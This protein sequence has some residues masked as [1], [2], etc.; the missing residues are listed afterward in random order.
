MSTNDPLV[1]RTL[2]RYLERYGRQPA[3]AGPYRD[4][5]SF[6][7]GDPRY[8]ACPRCRTLLRVDEQCD[9]CGIL[10]Q[11]LDAAGGAAAEDPF[12]GFTLSPRAA[13]IEAGVELTS[14]I[15]RRVC[16]GFA[17]AL[18]RC[19]HP[20]TLHDPVTTLRD[21]FTAGFSLRT[22]DD[23]RLLELPEGRLRIAPAHRQFYPGGDADEYLNMFKIPA[24]PCTH[25]EEYLLRPGDRVELRSA[26]A[27]VPALA[28]LDEPWRG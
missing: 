6:R 21:G 8:A 16:V 10:P 1:A 17:L 24:G 28:L 26:P 12:A 14:P 7:W 3:A 23:R 18:V 9:A 11:L 5:G 27:R 25:V 20:L 2:Q 19:R 15:T 13:V 22:D 4:D